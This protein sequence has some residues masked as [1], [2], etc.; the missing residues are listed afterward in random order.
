MFER[1]RLKFNIE[2]YSIEEIGDLQLAIMKLW[3]CATEKNLNNSYFSLESIQKAAITLPKRPILFAYSEIDNDFMEHEDFEQP[4]GYIPENGNNITY[5][6]QDDGRIFLVTDAIIWKYYAPQVIEI[7]A[8][9]NDNSRGCSMEIEIID[10]EKMEDGTL[11][12]KEFAFLAVTLLGKKY[13][14]GIENCKAEIIKFSKENFNEMVEEM[15][16]ILLKYSKKSNQLKDFPIPQNIQQLSNQILQSKTASAIELRAIRKFATASKVSLSFIN[17]NLK[18]FTNETILNWCNDLINSSNSLNNLTTN[19][20]AKEVIKDEMKFADKKDSST[21]D[22]DKKTIT[23]NNSKD[24][25]VDGTW[26]DVDLSAEKEKVQDAKN[27]KSVAKEFCLTLDD[28]WETNKDKMN[29]PHHIVNSDDNLV[30]HISGVRAAFKRAKQQGLTGAPIKHI[31]KHYVELGLSTEN[32]AS[33]G[34]TKEDVEFIFSKEGDNLSE[35][36]DK[37]NKTEYAAKFSMSAGQISDLLQSMCDGQTYTSDGGYEYSKYYVYDFDDTYCY[38]HDSENGGY[39]AIPYA[40]DGDGKAAL[41]FDNA[42]K[43]RSITQWVVDDGDGTDGDDGEDDEDGIIVI[44][45]QMSAAIEKQCA[46]KY[47]KEAKEKADEEAKRKE[48]MAADTKGDGPACDDCEGGEC[49]GCA[50]KNCEKESCKECDEEDKKQGYSLKKMAARFKK[51]EKE[52]IDT[53]NEVESFKKT[54]ET[55]E[56]E[57]K[58]LATFKATIEEQDRLAKIEYAIQSVSEKLTDEQVAEWRSKVAEFSNVDDFGNALKAFAF[59]IVVKNEDP[60]KKVEFNRIKINPDVSETEKTGSV[61]SRI[62][63]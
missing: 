45:K 50:C 6:E 12:I 60:N 40:I 15:D 2:K 10:S 8:N 42:K 18:Y 41:D 32:F 23:I 9:S 28:G 22:D 17:N 5:E 33:F 35:N 54:T 47:A 63:K 21:N 3:V 19:T 14:S 30:L 44:I 36:V 31:R 48:E 51:L 25:A 59:D 37:F 27:A 29:Y 49:P 62:G 26:S 61:W 52:L 11:N 46:D 38:C 7:F 34:L 43:A 55:L 4:C 24:S 16:K 1:Q 13:Q 57:N 39:A 56:T 53:K 58:A 20:T